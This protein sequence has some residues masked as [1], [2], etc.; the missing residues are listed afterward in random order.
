[1]KRYGWK[2]GQKLPLK[3]DI[4]PISLELTI[5]ATFKA[6]DENGVYFHHQAIE[7]AL[8]RVK[9]YVGWY[10]LKADSL[11][12]VQGLPRLID[13]M[14]ENSPYPTKTDTEKAFQDEW[15]SMLGNVR[16]LV[17]SIS[18]IIAV[19][20]LLIAA[21]TM[22]MAARERV[23]EIAVLRTLG[24]QKRTILGL[25][26][27]ESLLL[28]LIG[29]VLGLGIFVLLFEGIREGLLNS[30]MGTF[31]AGVQ[32]FPEVLAAGFGVSVLVGLFAGLVPAIRSAQ[33]S[34]TD[35]LRQSG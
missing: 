9:G 19:V 17:T 21:N 25:V 5:R 24:F 14:F 28:A 18:L 15:V 10:W 32:L 35:G 16:L 26:L 29:G 1:M 2:L 13:S 22:S 31:A 6:A 4:Y 27:G 11:E 8:P 20:I 23:T 34:I 7:E 30:P 33:R 12:A 3:G